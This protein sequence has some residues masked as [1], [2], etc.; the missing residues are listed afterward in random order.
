MAVTNTLAYFEMATIMTKKSFIVQTLC[1]DDNES[2]NTLGSILQ[3][4][5][6]FV[7]F[8]LAK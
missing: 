1:C 8:E 3:K 6:F 4:T 5:L 2:N 7:T